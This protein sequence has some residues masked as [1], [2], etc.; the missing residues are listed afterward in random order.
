MRKI[1]LTAAIAL[2]AATVSAQEYRQT[3]TGAYRNETGTNAYN[4]RTDRDAYGVRNDGDAYARRADRN[5]YGQRADGDAYPSRTNREAFR[6]EASR[7]AVGPQIGIYMNTDMDGAVFGVGAYGRYSITNHWRV[8]PAVTAL[9]ESN[10]SVDISADIQY[11]FQVARRWDVYPQVGVGA[12]DFGDWSCGIDFGVGTDF[13]V[14][15]RWDVTASFK[16]IIQTA[17]NRNDPFLINVGA[18]YRF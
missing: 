11:L 5:T 4:D 17:S 18:S 10:C 6:T 12:N 2:F 9:F 3:R 8:Q 14:S 15:R 16:W 13:A 7:W 1:F